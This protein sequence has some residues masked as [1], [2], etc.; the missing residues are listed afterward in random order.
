M[1]PSKVNACGT[2]ITCFNS[3]SETVANANIA[4]SIQRTSKG[5]TNNI[6][7]KVQ[8]EETRET[9]RIGNHLAMYNRTYSIN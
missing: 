8:E 3:R 2:I 6:R 9:K 4:I 5:H 1:C 7:E